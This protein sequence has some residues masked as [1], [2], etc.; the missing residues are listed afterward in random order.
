M[1]VV[2]FDPPLAEP[3]VDARVEAAVSPCLI[4]RDECLEVELGIDPVPQ[5]PARRGRTGRELTRRQPR[6]VRQR[7]HWK[8]YQSR[9][10]RL[11]KE[12]ENIQP[13]QSNVTLR[14]FG[15]PRPSHGCGTPVWRGPTRDG[16]RSRSFRNS[17]SSAEKRGVQS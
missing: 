11:D 6:L 9:P 14:P 1:A 12:A 13:R 10:R 15:A 7:R 17:R 16:L 4:L 5:L 2:R 3:E 8:K